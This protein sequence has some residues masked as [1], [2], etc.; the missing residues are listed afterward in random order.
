MF[1]D[2]K[3]EETKHNL[4]LL[5]SEVVEQTTETPTIAPAYATFTITG[6]SCPGC[7]GYGWH[8][9]TNSSIM[10]FTCTGL[11]VKQDGFYLISPDL[12]VDTSGRSRDHIQIFVAD[13]VSLD[14]EIKTACVSTVWLRQGQQI[15]FMTT[16]RD[17]QFVAGTGLRV[18]KM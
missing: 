7:S 13:K 8:T 2:I 10:D 18:Q 15:T 17:R 11:T 16:A 5:E 14:E 9:M 4:K 1:I 6:F 3:L 12:P